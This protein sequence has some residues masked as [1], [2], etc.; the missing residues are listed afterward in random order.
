MEITESK[1]RILSE[2]FIL[3]A[4]KCIDLKKYNSALRY[5]T[6]AAGLLYDFEWCYQDKKI[7][8]A[9]L[10][11]SDSVIRKEFF[12]VCDRYIF[13]D[14]FTH[15]YKALTLQYLKALISNNCEFL[16]ISRIPLNA[17]RNLIISE[18]IS[19]YLG[20]SYRQIA[21]SGI[22]ASKEI[23]SICK[24]YSA[25]KVI[26]QLMPD[27]IT[28]M[29]A[30]AA[31][32]PSITR[33]QV[34]LTD[35]AFWAGICISD[36]VLEFRDYGCSLSQK[37]REI[38]PTKELLL[39]FY[40]FINVE[41]KFLGLPFYTEDKIFIFSGGAIH[42]IMDSNL[43]FLNVIARMLKKRKNTVFAYAGTGGDAPKLI[44]FFKGEGLEDR[45][46]YLGH[47]GDINEIVKRCDIYI[48]TYPMGGGLMCQ[49]AAI[50]SKPIVSLT[51][52]SGRNIE[53]IV[54]QRR[55]LEFSCKTIQD[56]ESAIDKLIVSSE[57]RLSLGKKLYDCVMVDSIFNDL[58]IKTL[59]S[60]KS[61][62]A[63]KIQSKEIPPC[64]G[65]MMASQEI[66]TW[67]MIK[68]LGGLSIICH[69][70]LTIRVVVE[71]LLQSI[72]RKIKQLIYDENKSKGYCNI[73]TSV[74]SNSR[75]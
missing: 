65:I 29:I 60:N 37:Y 55:S 66:A 45:F 52:T 21:T 19:G 18:M 53:S 9:I 24:E 27:D 48:N 74:P 46:Y 70:I 30:F 38:D 75:E 12:E 1:A 33:Y 11:L 4:L 68:S 71:H 57:L 25:N 61:Q 17:Q 20:G 42:K 16:Y 36:Y 14:S 72:K 50:N 59:T 26:M 63:M 49:Y 67:R 23:Y 54:C 5:L 13:F 44:N 56:F 10:N 39:P 3:N 34:N 47:R 2:D 64:F 32:P 43:T 7:E 31:L 8:N 15:D 6:S 35:H 22:D 58:F 73:P 40:P 41:V 28:A 62:L 51:D 69:P